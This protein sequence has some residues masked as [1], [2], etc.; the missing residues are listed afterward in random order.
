MKVVTKQFTPEQYGAAE[1]YGPV[2]PAQWEIYAMLPAF[3]I[4]MVL[5][6]VMNLVT[7]LTKLE[8]LKEVA[9]AVAKAAIMKKV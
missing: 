5:M 6:M 1:V 4:I 7:S 8:V 3:A 2:Q 9:P